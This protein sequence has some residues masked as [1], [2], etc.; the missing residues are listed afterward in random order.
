[1]PDSFDQN[2]QDV[3]LSLDMIEEEIEQGLPLHADRLVAAYDCEEFFAGRN[4]AYIPRRESEEWRD[5]VKRPKRTSK[6]TRK[7][8][9]T[10][11]GG[12]YCPGP[13]RRLKDGAGPDAFLQ[14]VYEK[15]HVN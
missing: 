10:L 7:V 1:M 13:T 8:I 4:A 14:D 9:R 2:A 6:L 15:N 3:G 5:Y 11:A 12:L